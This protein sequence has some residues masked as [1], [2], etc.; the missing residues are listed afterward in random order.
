MR[1]VIAWFAQHTV[2][3]NMLMIGVLIAGTLAIF[4]VK[5]EVFPEFSSDMIQ[6]SVL[7]PG[8]APEEVEEGICVR[9]EE[10]LQGVEGIKRMR[11]TA[12]ESMGTVIV[13]VQ[14][15]YDTRELLDDVKNRV[16]A[17]DTFPEE[18]EKPVIQESI[19]RYQVIN[20]A[21]SG[22]ADERTIKALTERVREELL[23][24]P[25]ISQVELANVRP[26]EISIEV[27]EQALRRYNLTF[28]EVVQA[29]RRSSF[30]LPGG[31]VK[32]QAGE[33]LLRTKGQA[34]RGRQFEGLV[35]RT[36][37]DG[38]RL[39]LGD[40]ATVVDGFAE[41]DQSARFDGKPAGMVQVF[42]VGNE[43]ALD[44]SDAVKQ[45][46][47]EA[48]VRMPEGITLTTW[49]DDAK[50]LRSRLDLMIRNGRAGFIL[51]FIGLALFLRLRLA[52]WVSL[53]LVF[54]FFGAFWLMPVFDVSINLLSLFAF[55]VVLGIVVDDAIVV[56][57]NIY[58][59]VE[60]GESGL[61]AAVNGAT[62]MA[63]PV[64]FAVLTTIA[65]FSP[66][67]AIPGNT[68]KFM[69][70]V[71]IIV[72]A[73]LVF[74]LIESLLV[75][76]AH[77]SH[78]HPETSQP[79]RGLR[80]AWRRFQDNFARWLRVFIQK[81]YKPS[82]DLALR[83]RYSAIAVGIAT[84][85]LTLGLVIGGWIKFTFMPQ[86]D[87]DNVV[88]LLTMPQGT[89]AEVTAEAVRKLEG[90]AIELRRKLAEET[91][92]D[93]VVEHILASVGEQPFR[94]RQAM[95]P[96]QN[97]ASFSGAHL[98]EVNMQLLP[99]EI[100]GLPSPELAR[101]WRELSG[102][103]P[104][105]VELTFSS[106]LFSFG[107]PIDVQ[108]AGANYAALQQAAQELKNELAN[109]PGVYDIT[110]SFRE[111]KQ[112]MKLA[113]KPEAQSVGLTLL[114]LARQVRQAF[115]GEEAQRIQRGREE[116][117]VM[118]RYPAEERRSLA[119]ME[120]MRV[121]LPDGTEMPFSVAAEVD[122]GRGYSS[123]NRT[124]R[125][126]T[127]NVLADI[128]ESQAN[129]NEIVA[130]V[131]SLL[132]PDILANYPSVSYSLE[133]EQR[134]QRETMSGLISGFGM[135]L[136][137]IFVLLAI[138][139]RSYVQPLLVMSAIP[140]GLVGAIWGHVIMGKDL[141]ILSMFGIVALAGVVVN[142]SL[143]MVDFVNRARRAGL[144]IHEAIREAGVARFRPILLTSLTT[145]A[146]LTP[147]LLERSVQAQFLIPMAISLGFG[148]VFS[149][150]ITLVL[151]P[152]GYYILE[153]V[154]KAGY[155]LIGKP[156][157]EDDRLLEEMR[158]RG[159]IAEP[160][161]AW[162]EDSGNR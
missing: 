35:L 23:D 28:D 27:S 82:L 57:E 117:K 99:S 69:R 22:D 103:I 9:I 45:Y 20:V 84:L 158:D 91:G 92:Q 156:M 126:R 144:E 94:K 148:V 63:V 141:T 66:L 36:A 12:T 96:G 151:V 159:R 70:V 133:G 147:L 2:A 34:Y 102:P 150:F 112:E 153:D 76:P 75:L 29:V 98:G 100:R 89:P 125:K 162:I 17:I 143:V 136:L 4:G 56:G 127:V 18:T 149:T 47:K 93:N 38:S 113:I 10:A 43:S 72:I 138:P 118:V 116:I 42:R 37:P 59:N 114:D 152:V 105:A 78:L 64:V 65:A 24:L 21:V 61:K 5:K 157:P 115:Y 50:I 107:K 108:L 119:D 40:V 25:G 121:R 48:Q 60:R 85:V 54:S 135:A 13:E 39:Y 87:A 90:S 53:G 7:Y 120:N 139:F 111:G 41:T 137:L 80:G 132:L 145:F 11:S 6:V 14:P 79:K 86:V 161:P 160:V 49:Q 31:S 30:D 55:I 77:L 32:T 71:P 140:F 109:Y 95:R 44:V 110:D 106:S 26:Y 51:V 8:A 58:T 73:T 131:T 62:E 146:G 88:A 142:S 154:I 81:A 128:D 134:E 130:D 124:D 83:W 101:R 52:F 3:A 129:A 104:G 15:G 33:I 19:V 67:L 155:K 122:P 68:G 97:A 46:V 16:D 1:G 74:S 123:I